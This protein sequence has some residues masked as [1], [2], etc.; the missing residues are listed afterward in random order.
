L[1]GTCVWRVTL[2][3][4][5]GPVLFKFLTDGNFDKTPDFG[6]D[7]AVTLD[8]PGGPYATERVTGTGTAI[9]INVAAAG[10]YTFILD[11]RALT[12]SAFPPP[13]GSIEGTVSFANLSS[14]PFPS[15][16]VEAFSGATSAAVVTT[17]PNTRAF[18]L[19]GLDGGTYRVVVSASCFATR[20]L[21]S[22]TVAGG[23]NDV[24]DVALSEGAS[25]ST[26]ID[27]VGGFNNFTP[28]ADPM[29]ESP[30]CVWT[31]ERFVNTGVY[32]M[33]FFIDAQPEP[34]YGGDGSVVIPIPGGGPVQ[35]FETGGTSVQIQVANEGVYRF[36]LDERLQ[37]W[38]AVLVTPAP[39]RGEER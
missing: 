7:E 13:G 11:E 6:G 9:K 16:R 32:F 31:R 21:P 23:V 2:Q 38:S 39:A 20:E 10:A 14:A 29:V 18:S 22:V 30:P 4:N 3:L 17:D 37:Q 5:A 36:T 19:A 1:N 35:R 12:W 25:S 34:S 24:G 33:K 15:A 8:V 27:L 26:T 28:G